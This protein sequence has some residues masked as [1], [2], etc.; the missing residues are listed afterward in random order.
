MSRCPDCENI[1][2]SSLISSGKGNGRCKECKGT[3]IDQAAS[4]LVQF[5]TLGLEGKNIPCKICSGTGQCQTCGGTGDVKYHHTA[6]TS[7]RSDDTSSDGYTWIAKIIG[8]L[9]VAF[10][11]IWL[12]FAVIVPL[13]V[14]DIALISLIAGLVKKKWN[15]YLFPLSIIGTIYVVLDFNLGWFT[16]AFVAN[17]SFL[18]DL[19]PILLYINIIAGLVAAYLFV[20][21]ILNIKNPEAK[22]DGEFSK[23][24]L[25]I[26]SC[27]LLVGG[28]TIGL[29]LY[30]GSTKHDKRLQIE[31][32][33]SENETPQT[34]VTSVEQVPTSNSNT[35]TT[36]QPNQQVQNGGFYIVCVTAVKSE[37]KAKSSCDELKKKGHQAGY[38]WIPDYASLS[39]AKLF[40]VYLGPYSTQY[41]CEVATD[42]YRKDHPEA[43]GLLVSQEH[44]RVQI[45]GIGKVVTTQIN[46]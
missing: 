31:T 14:I 24:N 37:E 11:V 38:L 43:Y 2:I 15:K 32:L 33:N 27:L 18:A 44:K 26:M 4:A 29:Q 7:S 6:P 16:K 23:R 36:V 12:V 8:F 17:V 40:S 21:N 35:S 41:D 25:I 13:V 1:D 10:I 5:G 46:K 19:I 39:G 45:N 28:L 42:E 22:E 34:V 20:R 3:G 9:I 30:L